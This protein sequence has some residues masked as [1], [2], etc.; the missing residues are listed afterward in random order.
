MVAKGFE[1]VI[2][3]PE[4]IILQYTDD[5]L[6]EGHNEEMVRQSMHAI[7]QHLKELNTSI[8]DSK[9]QGP[10]QEATFS[11]IY[12]IEGEKT[13]TESVLA[14]IQSIQRSIK[15]SYKLY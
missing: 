14:E 3:P 9:Q 15:R 1:S 12:W 11:G 4:V 5:T 13:V 7:A 10:S 6:T 2:L 8:P